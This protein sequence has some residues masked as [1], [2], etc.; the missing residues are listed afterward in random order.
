MW[1][2]EGVNSMEN[3]Q[4]FIGGEF[5]NAEGDRRFES[6]NP[7]TEE[8]WTSV[9]DAAP[10]DVDRAVRSAH[11]AFR[12]GPWPRMSATE[13]GD[14]LR[15]LADRLAK[16]GAE[17]GRIETTDTGKLLRETVWQA[18][19][20]AKIYRYFA[21]LAETLEGTVAPSPGNKLLNL[22]LH[23]PVGVV[24]AIIPWNSQLQ[25][26]AYKIGPALVTGNTIVVKASEDASAPLLAFAKIAAEVGFPPGV[27]NV[28]SGQAAT[29]AV[30]L[31]RHP[32]VR[33]IAFTGGVDTARR[34]IPNSADNLARVSLELGGKS[35]VIV[36][37]DADLDS[38]VNGQI[39][40]IFGASGQS[41]AAGSRLICQAGV[42]D[43]VLDR[44]RARLSTIR[45]GDPLDTKTDM[46]PL[47]TQRQ[48]E[49]IERLL[50]ESLSGGARLIA[51]GKRPERFDRGFYFEPTIVEC[52]DQ[53]FPI[54]QQELFGP[55]LSV[56]RFDD[57]K[58]AVALADDS[59]FAFA[60]GVFTRDL[61]K[62]LRVCRGIQAGRI[63]V[64]TYRATA[65]NVPFGGFRNSGYGREGGRDALLDYTE[66]KAIMINAT[67]EPVAD[68]F[69]MH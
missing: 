44:L 19:N 50:A 8:A 18:E 61:T 47:A 26:A 5:A 27:F 7:A 63:W 10:Q 36:F 40:G 21:S 22:V 67:G 53:S 11:D 1:P 54:V 24:A 66:T 56:L 38:V 33:R 51:G 23:E 15:A 68:P 57:E 12:T 2:I 42:Y 59:E 4:L 65:G 49:R 25:L 58:Q 43:E 17:I 64:N 35:P 52:T 20:T 46:G 37:D 13:R 6:I 34:L 14:L 41:C 3:Y 30:P 45:V 69:V 28:I 62:A 60:G 48:R 32:L 39:A 16:E 9:P 31:T 55:V 29:C